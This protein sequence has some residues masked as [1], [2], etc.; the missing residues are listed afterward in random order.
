M[1]LTVGNGVFRAHASAIPGLSARVLSVRFEEL[2]WMRLKDVHSCFPRGLGQTAT[3]ELGTKDGRS[4]GLDIH[5][6]AMDV[7][8]AVWSAGVPAE[9]ASGWV[10]RTYK[11]SRL[12]RALRP[13]T[14][15]LLFGI[16]LGLLTWL[17]TVLWS[18][19]GVAVGIVLVAH[20]VVLCPWYYQHLW[21]RMLVRAN[22][23][24]RR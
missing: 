21:Y 1:K 22:R 3:V 12:Q 8:D 16:L 20:M 14:A 15:W 5:L 9:Q 4:F 11:Q 19:V 23:E 24:D 7:L 13:Q 6:L 2:A 17:A 10:T 18:D